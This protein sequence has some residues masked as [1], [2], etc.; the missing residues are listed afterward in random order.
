MA[1][2]YNSN[3]CGA[4][5]VCCVLCAIEEL[6]KRSGETCTHCDKGCVIYE[7]RPQ[8]CRGFSCAYH[9]AKKVNI[10]LRPDNCGVMFE[11]LDDDLMV[12]I[13]DPDNTPTHL[14]GQIQSFMNEGL[15]VVILNQGQPTVYHQDAVDPTS[16]TKRI[17]NRIKEI[18]WQ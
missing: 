17:Y 18:S 14:N 5:T 12:G 8:P 6:D 3:K 4:C 15:N 10:A 13:I 2:T 9:Q 16:L 11:K 7:S 1:I